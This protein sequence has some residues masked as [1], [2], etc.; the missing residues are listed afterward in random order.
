MIQTFNINNMFSYLILQVQVF[1]VLKKFI[2][3]IYVGMNT[4]KSATEKNLA[5]HVTTLS[6]KPNGKVSLSSNMC[7]KMLMHLHRI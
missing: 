1:Y 6:V 7:L 3:C 5:K 2:N 4:F